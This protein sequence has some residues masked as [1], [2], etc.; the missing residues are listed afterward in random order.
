[1][2]KNSKIMIAGFRGM[3]GSAI[4]EALKSK[5]YENFV[6]A[7]LGDAD[8][9]RQEETEA[10]FE[11]KRPDYV[12]LA[13]AKVGGIVANN[14]YRAEFI[15]DN[16]AIALNVINSSYKVGV[17]KLL[18]LGS[19]CIYPKFAPQP[20]KEE[21]LLTGEL[22]QTNEPYAL[23]KIG[24]IK[25]CEAY[26]D[27]YDTNFISMMPTNLY[28]RNDN[29]NLET[30]HVLPAIVRKTYLAKKLKEGDWESLDA[31]LTRHKLGFGLDKT[32]DFRKHET[33]E[34]ALKQ[35]GVDSSGITLW[36]TGKVRREFLHAEDLAAACVFFMEGSDA[37]EL[38]GHVNIGC[39]EDLSIRELSEKIFELSGYDGEMRFDSS[40]P[41]GTP[42]KLLDVS[43]AKSFGWAPTISLE[44]GIRRVVE[45]MR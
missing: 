18:N 44:E 31:N 45:D 21:H 2:D 4:F 1:M 9:R 41:D 15:Y 12:F 6:K 30:S 27:Q 13:A 43:K 36:G 39:G 24:A 5:G 38:K 28:G 17:K 14:T 11:E 7:D 8:F 19:S 22:E 34:H 20:M 37:S 33:I 42:R 32:I 23:A 25:L 10:Y 16:L 29:Y 40:K 26:N 35:V 3:V